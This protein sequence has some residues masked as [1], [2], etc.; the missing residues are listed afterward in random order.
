[1]IVHAVWT[2][3]QVLAV[4]S[5]DDA[6]SAQ[7]K[8]IEVPRGKSYRLERVRAHGSDPFCMS[9]VE[10]RGGEPTRATYLGCPL[11]AGDAVATFH[12]PPIIGGK[13]TEY[14]I[15]VFRPNATFKAAAVVIHADIVK[16]PQ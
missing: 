11:P 3:L 10:R 6:R 15:V 12:E 4:M 8:I 13:D 5:F 16:E 1:M 2:I 14:L 9:V 7:T